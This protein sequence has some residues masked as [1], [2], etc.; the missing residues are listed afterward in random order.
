MGFPAARLSDL[1]T[2][3]GMS[4][5]IPHVSGPVC[6]GMPTVLIGGLPAARAGDLALCVGSLDMIQTGSESVRIGNQPAARVGDSSYHHGAIITGCPT[7][8]IG[9]RTEKVEVPATI[10]RAN[11]RYRIRILY[12]EALPVE[13]IPVTPFLKE[14]ATY[15]KIHIQILDTETNRQARFTLDWFGPSGSLTL[16]EGDEH[17]P[18]PPE[19]RADRERPELGRPG[20]WKDFG[21]PD[22]PLK[23]FAGKVWFYSHYPFPGSDLDLHF[24]DEDSQ[25]VGDEGW[26]K[27]I[28]PG[29]DFNPKAYPDPLR[30]LNDL[31]YDAGSEGPY[32][33]D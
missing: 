29:P 9:G 3:P 32:E 33:G 10:P 30:A 21:G 17:G 6:N 28:D 22:M 1:H 7:V 18:H 23:D 2:C 11:K 19:E 5:P 26:I 15:A 4:G 14:G 16:P 31:D 8:L 13:P 27:E 12:A 20:Q 25:A 24:L